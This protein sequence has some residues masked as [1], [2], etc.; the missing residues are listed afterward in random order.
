[1]LLATVFRYLEQYYCNLRG[2]VQLW[3]VSCQKQIDMLGDGRIGKISGLPLNE[4][5]H[6]N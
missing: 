5:A 2:H 3:D 4:P 6:L 1:M